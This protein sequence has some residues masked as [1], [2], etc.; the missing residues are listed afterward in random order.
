MKSNLMLRLFH[1]EWEKKCLDS[2]LSFSLLP[3]G[4]LETA[5]APEVGGSVRHQ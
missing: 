4:L 3:E 1:C 2:R 5:C